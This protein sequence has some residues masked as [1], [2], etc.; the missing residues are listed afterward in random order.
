M[1]DNYQPAP[2]PSRSAAPAA[3]CKRITIGEINQR[4]AQIGIRTHIAPDVAQRIRNTVDPEKFI[5]ALEKAVNSPTAKTWLLK[6]LEHHGLLDSRHVTPPSAD[7][8]DTTTENQMIDNTNAP[9]A[10]IIEEPSI[11]LPES[12]RMSYHVYGGKAA[13]CFN[14]DLTRKGFYTVALDGAMATAPRKYN[15]TD[16]IRIQMTNRELPDVLAVLLG[17]K[18]EC[19]YQNHGPQNNK[20]FRI[21]NQGAKFFVNLMEKGKKLVAVPMEHIDAFYAANL[22]MHQLQKNYDSEMAQNL[23][24]LLQRYSLLSQGTRR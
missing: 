21:E 23:P 13:L 12:E 20:G 14:A 22:L 10:P 2:I 3:Q 1:N 24:F 19:A 6:L 15:W 11:K 7:L 17:Y 8:N 4:L 5:D 9:D 18:P 16:K